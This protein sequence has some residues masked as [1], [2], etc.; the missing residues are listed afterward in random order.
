MQLIPEMLSIAVGYADLPNASTKAAF[1]SALTQKP[2]RAVP[3]VKA[4][5]VHIAKWFLPEASFTWSSLLAQA[6]ESYDD[7][8]FGWLA[9]L[10]EDAAA[11]CANGAENEIVQGQRHALLGTHSMLSW[12]Q[13]TSLWKRK[14]DSL[15][16]MVDGTPVAPKGS[17]SATGYDER[18]IWEM[19]IRP[20]KGHCYGQLSP[21]IQK[22][23]G[24]AWT[25]GRPV[26]LERLYENLSKKEFAFLT[27]QDRA[28]CKCI[29]QSARPG[30][31]HGSP[32]T[33]NDL[34]LYYARHD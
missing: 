3:L 6:A 17:P 11:V 34:S 12:I 27:D 20:Y 14:L 33:G 1:K 21:F 18:M 16:Q 25:K 15:R 24:G 19:E 28:V 5:V 31:S 30:A 10:C 8:G 7:L 32:A 26:A 4:M 13:Q 23:S 22:L 9:A 2:Q 29:K